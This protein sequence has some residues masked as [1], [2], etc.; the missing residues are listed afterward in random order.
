MPFDEDIDNVII[1]WI[2]TE[3]HRLVTEAGVQTVHT[4]EL[5]T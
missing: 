2:L 1:M 4:N 5:N 3:V